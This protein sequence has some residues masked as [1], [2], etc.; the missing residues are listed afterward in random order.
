[1]H[2][3]CCK[4]WHE[5]EPAQ[6]ICPE[7]G[8]AISSE[9]DN[10][11][12]KYIA[13]IRHAEPTRASL[14]IYVLGELMREPRATGPLIELIEASTNAYIVADA[15]RALGRLGARAAVPALGR[16]LLEPA[17]QLVIR[18]AAVKALHDIGGP[19]ALAFVRLAL[20]DPSA[21]VRADAKTY[22]SPKE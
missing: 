18:V 5:I 2:Y 11:V 10:L 7:C 6:A 17:T 14:A 20:A 22:G 12:D 21:S 3:Y 9:A 19:E 8:A 13:A 1:V 16:L 4:C 15:V